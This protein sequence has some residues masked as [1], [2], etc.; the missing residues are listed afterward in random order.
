MFL[1]Y[2][3]ADGAFQEMGSDL[4][5]DQVVRCTGLHGFYIDIVASLAGEQDNRHL[6]PA[7]DYLAQKLHTVSC[8]ETIIKEIDV[9]L[10]A[11]NPFDTCVIRSYPLQMKLCRADLR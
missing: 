7:C 4:S 6:T 5:F 9:V 1:H 10:G 3:V 2:G 11:T 8:A